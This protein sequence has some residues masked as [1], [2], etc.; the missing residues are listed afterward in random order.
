MTS[1]HQEHDGRGRCH[2]FRVQITP[3]NG[4]KQSQSVDRPVSGSLAGVDVLGEV[5]RQADALDRAEL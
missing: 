4:A 3:E 2:M 1:S 5:L